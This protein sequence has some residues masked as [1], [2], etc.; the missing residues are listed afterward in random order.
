[1]LLNLMI[2]FLAILALISNVWK[3]A[4]TAQDKKF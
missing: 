1:M 3:K 2:L 4:S